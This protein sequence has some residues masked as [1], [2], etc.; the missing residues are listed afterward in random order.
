M[1]FKNLNGKS[2]SA[3][4]IGI[5]LILSSCKKDFPPIFKGGGF[6]GEKP[7]V[8]VAG[9]EW[10]GS[11]HV[12]KYWVDGQ[13]VILSDG[14]G[15][16]ITSSIFVSNNDVYVAGSDYKDFGGAVYWKNN[17]EIQLSVGG[18]A[19]SI[20][21]S[22]NDAYV[23]GN[24]GEDPVYWKN[25]TQVDLVRTNVYGIFG[26]AT[27]NSIFVSG[28][29][30]YVAG[31]DG[32]NAVYWKNGEEKYLTTKNTTAGGIYVGNSIYVSGP[33]VYIV[34]YIIAATPPFPEIWYWKNE[35][36]FP[37]NKVDSFGQ[38]S[39]IFVSGNDVY[40]AGAK[41]SD[42]ASG[43]ETAT[44]WKNGHNNQL[45]NNGLNSWANS[46]FVSGKDVYAAGYESLNPHSTYAVYWKNGVATKLTDSTQVSLATSVFVK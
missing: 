14:T 29:D 38:A 11:N 32:P 6:P 1:Y 20:F 33:D 24:V 36:L 12:A 4:V 9:E 26:S 8:F 7:I 13:E 39:S 44:F 18:A 43:I 45:S 41:I 19:S 37:V 17:N 46:I 22:G 21:V 23:A 27:A 5:M 42:P 2:L 25:G 15:D 3:V 35:V 16:A 40:I 31:N 34:G 28:N 30:I 10:N